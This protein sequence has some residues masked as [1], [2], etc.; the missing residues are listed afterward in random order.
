MVFY[1]YIQL[2]LRMWSQFG[3]NLLNNIWG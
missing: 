3:H 2:F 1:D